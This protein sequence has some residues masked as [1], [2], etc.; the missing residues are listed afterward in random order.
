MG[1]QDSAGSVCRASWHLTIAFPG[2][3]ILQGKKT[4]SGQVELGERPEIQQVSYTTGEEKG[5]PPLGT[6]EQ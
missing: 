5:K 2:E 4:I 3:S 6:S 1:F